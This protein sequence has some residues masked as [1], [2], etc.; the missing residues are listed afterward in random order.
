[1][2][3]YRFVSRSSLPK[4]LRLRWGRVQETVLKNSYAPH[5]RARPTL[6]PKVTYYEFLQE[7]WWLQTSHDAHNFS[8]AFTST[9]SHL[10]VQSSKSNKFEST[11]LMRTKCSRGW[12]GSSLSR[13]SSLAIFSLESLK[14]ISQE[15][16]RGSERALKKLMRLFRS[17][18]GQECA[19]WRGI[20]GIYTLTKT[21]HW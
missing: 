2:E 19:G 9:P 21:S 20:G 8:W 3:R 6:K 7:E 4:K 16:K 12:N 10:G 11:G 13:I 5:P 1:M 18:N 14:G 17:R 15:M